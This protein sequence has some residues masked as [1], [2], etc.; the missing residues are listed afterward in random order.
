MTTP[1]SSPNPGFDRE[2]DHAY[3]GIKEYD[4]PLPSWWVWLFAGSVVWA[5]AYVPYYHFGPGELPTERYAA[6]MAEHYAKHPPFVLPPAAELEAVLADATAVE[7]GKLV[8][9]TRCAACHAPDGGGLVGPN[10]TD[11]FSLHGFGMSALVATIYHGVPEKGMQAWGPV[12]PK[13][14]VYAVAAYVHTLRGTTPAT[15]KE[16]QGEPIA[17][18]GGSGE[19]NDRAAR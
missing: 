11:D 5:A 7:K 18:V 4:N 13:D 16:P 2:F 17:A 19:T 9:T 10:L 12:L 8:Y 14:E 3:D 15:P 6:A 1:G